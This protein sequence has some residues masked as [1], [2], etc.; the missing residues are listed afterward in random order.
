LRWLP[1]SSRE[2]AGPSAV[3]AFGLVLG[4]LESLAKQLN[5]SG[6]ESAP[7]RVE[8]ME[9]EFIGEL[10]FLLKTFF[11][12]FLGISMRPADLWSPLAFATV[13]LLLLVRFVMVRF[14]LAGV[15]SGRAD[16]SIVASLIPKGLAAAVMAAAAAA[17]PDF[18]KG[19]EVDNL[20]YAVIFFSI[21]TTA[22]LVF[23]FENTPLH[24]VFSG[25][26]FRES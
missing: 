4:N 1:A 16:A 14:L 18:P 13:G 7:A 2:L 25:W 26:W 12:V 17:T 10:V 21:V 20:I 3:L 8:R 9:A 22:L 19:D 6:N 5:W 23:L 24:R 11:F 15:I